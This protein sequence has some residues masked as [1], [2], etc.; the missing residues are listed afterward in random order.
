[1]KKEISGSVGL[2]AGGMGWQ[3]TVKAQ[4]RIWDRDRDI[5]YIDCGGGYKSVY[6]CQNSLHFIVF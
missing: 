1:M 6:V 3:L 4:E 5:I 2:G